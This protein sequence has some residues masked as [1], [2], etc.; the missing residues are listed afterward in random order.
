MNIT[1]LNIMVARDDFAR[2]DGAGGGKIRDLEA[3]REDIRDS[4]SGNG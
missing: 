4:A 1:R 2:I 3:K